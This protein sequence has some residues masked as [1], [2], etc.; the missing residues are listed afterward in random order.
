MTNV[1]ASEMHNSQ[2]YSVKLQ[3][4]VTTDEIFINKASHRPSP[5]H[6]SFLYNIVSIFEIFVKG[7]VMHNANIAVQ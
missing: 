6:D 4:S 1:S 7:N 2:Y 3:Q 5:Q